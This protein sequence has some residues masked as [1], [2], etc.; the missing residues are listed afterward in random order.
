MPLLRSGLRGCS[1]IKVPCLSKGNAA[2]WNS[3]LWE[4]MFGETLFPR[5]YHSGNR[6][7]RVTGSTMPAAAYAKNYGRL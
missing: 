3:I 7:Y 5:K 2:E 6:K 4:I 1:G